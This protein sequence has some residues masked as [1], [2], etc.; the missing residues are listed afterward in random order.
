VKEGGLFTT[1]AVGAM[2]GSMLSRSIG[3]MPETQE[4]LVNRAVDDLNDPEHENEMRKIRA[5]T[6]LTGMLTDPDDSISSHDPDR[7]LT[8]FNEISQMAPRSADQPGVLRPLLRRRLTGH[9]EP[10]EAKEIT[11][12]EQGLHKSKTQGLSQTKNDKP[13]AP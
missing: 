13:K 1:P 11:D 4:Q 3:E 8:A 7:V 5:Q 12:I 2:L 6:M 9:T 10:F